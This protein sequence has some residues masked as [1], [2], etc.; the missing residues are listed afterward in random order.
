VLP[1]SETHVELAAQRAGTLILR[2]ALPIPVGLSIHISDGAGGQAWH[3]LRPT[4]TGAGWE[5]RRDLPSGEQ[6]WALALRS[7]PG[8]PR[9]LPPTAEL[10]AGRLQIEAGE[11]H[12]VE[13]V[14][15]E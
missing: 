8:S 1:G 6:R 12:V 5:V 7:P 2:G 14:L 11:T 4:I 3:W 10:T 13:V 9:P 15:P